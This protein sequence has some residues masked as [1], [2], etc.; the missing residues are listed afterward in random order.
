MSVPN[1]NS[2]TLRPVIGELATLTAFLEDFA[3]RHGL[4]PADCNACTLAAEELFANTLRHADPP[5]TEIHFTL[6]PQG[7]ATYSDDGPAFDPTT[8]P[9]P[10]I[11][12]P[13]EQRQIGGL[14]IYFIRRTMKTFCY[15]RRDGRNITTFSRE[16]G[17]AGGEQ[18]PGHRDQ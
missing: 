18:G 4:S 14:G 1:P 13:P 11:T 10:D 3:E 12:L 5:A 7:L 2:L 15:E 17:P 8:L 16:Q 9:D 6:T